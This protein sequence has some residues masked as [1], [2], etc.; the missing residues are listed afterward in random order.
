MIIRTATNSDLNA[1]MSIYD[2]ARD[3]M[4]ANGN[5]TQWGDDHPSRAII[6][7]DIEIGHLYVAITDDN[8][9]HG[10]FVL[11]MG[12]DPT[13]S[14]IEQ[15]QWKNDFAYGTI[16][17]I[18]ADGMVKGI[19]KACIDYSKTVI[20][21]IRCDTHHDNIIMQ[22]VL[23]KNGFEACGVVYVED[24]SPRIAYHYNK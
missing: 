2:S 6:Q 7:E 14:Y 18:A 3:Y 23:E 11:A 13:Y 1:I 12:D 20:G 19:S 16:H 8:L 17:R 22:K 4:K 21:N 24:G 10:V 5:P 15:G 9:I